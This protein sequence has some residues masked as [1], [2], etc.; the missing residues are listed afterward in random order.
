V[1]AIVTDGPTWRAAAYVLVAA[2][3][4][5]LE[6]AVGV[7]GAI[8]VPVGLWVAP[9][10]VWGHLAL[11]RVLLGQNRSDRLEA[12]T[13]RLVASRARGVDAAEAER[14]RIERDLHDGAQQRLVAV[15]MNLGRA[16]AK[17]D[18]DPLAV[19]G[20]LDEAH[21]DA[22]LAIAELRDLAR[23]IHPPVLTD[24][25]L[26]AALSALAASAPLPVRV[27]VDAS[28]GAAARP[29]AAVE[30]TAYFTVSE[31]LANA[32]KHAGAS[33]V[34]VRVWRSP[35]LGRPEGPGA[36]G[37][38]DPGAVVVEVTDDGRGGAVV[39][40]GGGL[41]GLADRA[42][43]IDGVVTVVSPVGG[44]TVLRADL[45]CRW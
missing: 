41:A 8:V 20:L 40:P 9:W 45:P 38:D 16:R 44:G 36:D 22:K 30:T 21:T 34:G 43:V 2:V 26:D 39:R 15:A 32:A 19:R 35:M 10:V 11:A 29:P 23:G 42:A 1:R 13:E 24:R 3:L 25:G 28:F 5:P 6:F 33:R 18:S 37:T 17:V 31:A 12:T 4:A 14:R 7:V 27:C